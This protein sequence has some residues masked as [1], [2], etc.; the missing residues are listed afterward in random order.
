M[1]SVIVDLIPSIG[2]P[3]IVPQ[4]LNTTT[5]GA[6]VDMA[7]GEIATNCIIDVGAVTGTTPSISGQIEQSTTSASGG[8]WT[9]IPGINTFNITSSSPNEI[10]LLGQRTYRWARLNITTSSGTSPVVLIS[11]T[12]KAQNK[13]SPAG[14]TGYSR[15]PN[16]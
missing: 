2:G 7:M 13:S 15:S 6:A 12:F 3:T 8:P 14:T 9:I 4:S 16:S 1:A 5:T 11:A 10:I